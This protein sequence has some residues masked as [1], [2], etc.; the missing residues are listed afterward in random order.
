MRHSWLTKF[1]VLC[2][3]QLVRA[4]QAQSIVLE[5]S[6]SRLEHQRQLLPRLPASRQSTPPGDRRRV[7]LLWVQRF[8]AGHPLAS[9]LLTP[10]F[11]S[12]YIRVCL[13]SRP[14]A[15]Q[16]PLKHGN[17]GS[18]QYTSSVHAVRSRSRGEDSR[19][20]PGDR[21]S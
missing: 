6:A 14:P 13:A 2:L 11:G 4:S 5:S 3:D 16:A 18:S 10:S 17:P 9:G 8:A 21:L 12:R 7:L 19:G 15:Q 1:G 20:T